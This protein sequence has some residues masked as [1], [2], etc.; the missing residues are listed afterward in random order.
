MACI[1]RMVGC[2]K[3]QK[4]LLA[5][6]ADTV[7]RDTRDVI[8]L[9]VER[10]RAVGNHM[11]IIR[12]AVD[13]N[14]IGALGEEVDGRRTEQREVRYIHHTFEEGLSALEEQYN[15]HFIRAALLE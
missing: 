11:I 2:I 14:A 7:P 15:L 6:V 4:G 8:Y 3:R 13:V 5:F 9:K 1:F 12:R 10:P